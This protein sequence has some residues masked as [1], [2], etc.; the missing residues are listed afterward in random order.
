M[1]VQV[2]QSCNWNKEQQR[3]KGEDVPELE[4]AACFC[5]SGEAGL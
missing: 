1:P 5:A 3:T 2:H 4:L